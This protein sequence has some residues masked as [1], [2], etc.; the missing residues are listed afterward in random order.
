MSPK[1]AVVKYHE[2]NRLNIPVYLNPDGSTIRPV[3]LDFF[4]ANQYFSIE[5]FIISEVYNIR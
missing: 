2:D 1:V 3:G 4:A 5:Y